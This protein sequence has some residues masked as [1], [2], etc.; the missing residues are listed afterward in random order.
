M[1]LAS[2]ALLTDRYA[3]A[4]LGA[5][6]REG[7]AERRAVF[8][9]SVRRLPPHRRFLLV[10]GVDRAVRY[11]RD[12]RFDDREIAHLRT[13]PG[14]ADVMSDAMVSY[15]REFRFRGDV[16][17]MPEGEVAFEGEPLVRIEG[18]LADGQILETFLLGVINAETRVASKAA[19]VVAAAEGRAVLEFGARRGDPFAAPF[20]ARAAWVAGC[21]ASSCEAAGAMFGVPVAGTCA[22]SYVLAHVDDGEP[23]AFARFT[24]AFPSGASL[25]IDTFDTR[26]GALHA[27][28]A[29]PA[30]RAVRVDSGDLL[31][32]GPDVRRILDAAGRR[33]V[34]MVAS[35]DLD[36]H[37]IRAL[38]RGGA[39]YD[40][41]GVGTA[42]ALTPD[43]PSLGAIYKLV[44]I[45]D[46]R[47]V[48]VPVGKRSPGKP[49]GGGA[50]QVWR[51]RDLRGAMVGDLVGRADPA[52]E[53][54]AV[55][56]AEP[57]LVPVMRRG[58]LV[59]E[60]LDDRAATA[61]ARQRAARAVASLPPALRDIDGDFTAYPVTLT[62][63]LTRWAGRTE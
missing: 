36:E 54:A 39:G 38:V 3:L 7:V 11:L 1:D 57:M 34:Q 15:L 26:Q 19:R 61:L 24:E 45:E 12:L 10:A 25:L 20:A 50:R 2:A 53:T 60:A 29:G 14:L 23:V 28:A 46:R 16:D 35:D 51:Q 5:Y 32:L 37:R 6:L 43:A 40:A 63:A 22:H 13:A 8:E 17:A 4:M 21:A 9:L 42:I 58:K 41:F 18:T 27:A 31:A 59:H 48:R 33:D 52:E 55:A 30:V 49:T 44:E 62:E 56:G 47:G